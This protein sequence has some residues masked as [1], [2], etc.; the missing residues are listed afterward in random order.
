MQTEYYDFIGA[1]KIMRAAARRGGMAFIP[2][3]FKPVP[4]AIVEI[5]KT[6]TLASVWN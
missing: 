6:K 1:W 4:P 2:V 3:K 5:R